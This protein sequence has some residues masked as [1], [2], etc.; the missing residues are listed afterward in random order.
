MPSCLVCSQTIE[1]LRRNIERSRDELLGLLQQLNG[2]G[3]RIVGYA[4]TPKSTTVINYCRI[5][6]GLREFI[7][8]TTPSQSSIDV[9]CQTSA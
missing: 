6:P 2:Q 5:T 3:K 1:V 9:N 8:D 4:A 7:S